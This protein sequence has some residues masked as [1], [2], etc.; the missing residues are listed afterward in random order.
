DFLT[1]IVI[2]VS[3]LRRDI[4]ILRGDRQLLP[5]LLGF[6]FTA[7]N[8]ETVLVEASAGS[9]GQT[10]RVGRADHGNIVGACVLQAGICT[11]IQEV[12]RAKRIDAAQLE[13]LAAEG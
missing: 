9:E 11:D 13:R 4:G 12:A 2:S 7:T 10:R 3:R 1:E 6:K 5:A 8:R